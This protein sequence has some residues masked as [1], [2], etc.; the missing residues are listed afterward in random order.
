MLG[1]AATLEDVGNVAAF[2]ASDYARTLN[3]TCGTVVDQRVP[4]GPVQ[5]GAPAARG[6]RGARSLLLRS[7]RAALQGVRVIR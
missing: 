6:G 5:H 1:R 3:I 7:L 4:P 2:A